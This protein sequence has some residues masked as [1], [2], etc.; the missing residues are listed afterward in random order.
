MP[1]YVYR[2]RKCGN[3][4]EK[5]QKISEPPTVRCPVCRATADRVITGGGGF[6]LKGTGFYSTDYRSERYKKAAKAE[7][8]ADASA[9]AKDGGE[10]K[11]AAPAR[12]ASGESG[13]SKSKPR[14]GKETSEE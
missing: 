8:P 13:G 3:E 6:L 14:A 1:T 4:F 12:E 7:T 5:F 2:C 11:P 9:S 10:S